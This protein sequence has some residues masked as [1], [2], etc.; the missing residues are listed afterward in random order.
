MF[1]LLEYLKKER[2]L[3]LD[4]ERKKNELKEEIVR[5]LDV[6][7]KEVGWIV[8]TDCKEKDRNREEDRE[9]E[10]AFMKK[11]EK[12]WEKLTREVGSLTAQ[13]RFMAKDIG[14]IQ[15]TLK[16]IEK[17]HETFAAAMPSL[18]PAKEE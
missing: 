10:D 12:Q 4:L 5:R 1:Q 18:E 3:G 9:R 2:F 11:N 16:K 6:E 17:S 13:T 8:S 7:T 14:G 15:L